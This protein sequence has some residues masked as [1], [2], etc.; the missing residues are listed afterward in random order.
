MQNR[1]TSFIKRTAVMF[2]A[3]LLAGS[4]TSYAGP[5]MPGTSAAMPGETPV[6]P[7]FSQAAQAYNQYPDV[8]Y[9]QPQENNYLGGATLT[10]LAPAT[11][12]QNLSSVIQTKN[13][14][15]IVIDGGLREDMPH[16][17]ETIQQKGGR[18]AAWLITHPHSD[19]IGALTEILNQN[20]MP[21]E[22]DRIYYSFLERETYQNGE[23]MGRMSDLDNLQAAFGRIP[24]EKLQTPLAKG[25]KIQV[26]DVTINVMNLPFRSLYNTFN[27]SSVAYRLDVG[28]KRIL[29]LG[30]MG[31]EAGQN[32]LSKCDP[33]ELKADVV[34]MAHH[35]QDGVEEGVYRV[36]RPEICLWPTPDWLW[37]NVKNGQ[38]GA[39]SWKTLTVR[40]W[41]ENMGVQRNLVVKDGDQV[42]R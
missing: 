15:L 26:D 18:V 3:V 39:G 5:V 20:P 11:Q 34:Q 41:M 42:L 9:E 35:G 8:V 23:N 24:Q 33:A 36:I 27:N 2:M 10:L 17:V 28:G 31:W 19:H 14:S 12:S 37:D 16:L 40:S 32:L 30:D 4:M 38:A 13:G 25:Q 1:K 29:F 6:L 21:V 7:A 22:I